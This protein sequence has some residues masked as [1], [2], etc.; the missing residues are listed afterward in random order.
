MRE[1]LEALRRNIASV[2]LGLPPST[3]GGNKRAVPTGLD[4]TLCC[5]LARGHVLIEDVPGVGK[6]LLATALA[7]SIDCTFS[8][9]Q[10]TPDLLPSDILGVS[11]YEGRLG[12]GGGADNG[13]RGGGEFVFKP[14][15]LFAN[16]VL[17][18]EVNRTPPRT[19]SAL[20]E[21]MSE[22]TVSIDGTP[23]ELGHPFMVIGTQNPYDF[24]GTYPLPENQLDRFLMRIRLGYPDAQTEAR[25][26]RER[27]SGKGLA[28]LTPVL[29]RKQVLEMQERVDEV[30][31]ADS[32]IDYI[33]RLAGSSRVHEGLVHGLSP[34]GALALS[35]S[36]RAWAFM[37]ERDYVVPDDIQALWQSVCG[38]R[39]VM[40]SAS[41]QRESE[42]IV[43][44][45]LQSVPSPV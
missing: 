2:Y 44:E 27:P 31:L 22:G 7:R 17:A 9:I 33:V 34:R 11:V 32:L 14:G 4:L 13:E 45:I 20:L 35:Q 26:L 5:L 37:Q 30:T 36:S 18:D 23:G 28:A 12:G 39:M 25:V 42:S 40:R 1:V 19:Q 15:P 38:H 3:V 6:T 43:R 41:G 10:L 16:I 8:R 21:A 24:E 29:T